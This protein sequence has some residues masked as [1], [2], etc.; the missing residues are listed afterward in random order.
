[1]KA[2]FK[3]ILVGA[4]ALALLSWPIAGG[5]NAAWAG[6][7]IRATT[8]VNVRSGPGTDR[9]IIGYVAWGWTAES[10]GPAAD[11][12]IPISYQGKQGYVSAQYF[13]SAGGGASA[14]TTSAGAAGSARTTAA[15]NV[16]SGPSVGHSRLD[17]LAQGAQVVLTGAT[18]G[19]F[20][21]I[22]WNGQRAWVSASWL[23]EGA[24]QA[25]AA[26]A[27]PAPAPSLPAVTGQ[28]R[29]TAALNMRA[30]AD[31]VSRIITVIPSG[32]TLD[33][34]GAAASG[35]IQ[36][37]RDGQAGW[38]ASEYVAELAAE[39]PSAPAAPVVAGVLYATT[40]VNVRTQASV[41]SQIAGLLTAG[42]SVQI[43]G[44]TDNGWNEVVY[45]G[46]QRWVSSQYLTSSAPTQSGQA[47]GTPK[48]IARAQV[49][50]RGWPADEYN[51]LVKLWDRES[52]WR[53]NASNPSSGAYGIPQALPGSKMASAGA[54]WQ[55]NPAT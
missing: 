45:G 52:G 30:E 10:T 55:T 19:D 1:M 43:T 46:A 12:W 7:T 23:T 6:E 34:T 54:D 5:F 13:T 28:K 14:P 20:A 33:V 35:R 11:G 44:V 4:G 36:V 2:R 21:E 49:A 31:A 22:E 18:S 3:R 8:T 32:A 37:V 47:S 39:G 48:E 50:E 29:A 24:G 38:V 9:A 40:A 15:L 42:Q 41:N 25:A 17:T 53:V 26:P 27:D 16:R 51:C